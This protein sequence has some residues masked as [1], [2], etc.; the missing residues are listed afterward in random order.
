MSSATQPNVGD[1]EHRRS[2]KVGHP[3]PAV[4]FLNQKA[5]LRHLIERLADRRSADA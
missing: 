2:V 3:K 4:R 1:V 5:F